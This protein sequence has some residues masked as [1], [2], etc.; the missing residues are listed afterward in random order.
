MSAEEREELEIQ[1]MKK[2]QFK[3]NPINAGIFVASGPSKKVE[4][5]ASTV[6]VEFHLSSGN[7]THSNAESIVEKS[8]PFKA[9]PV[10][11]SVFEK[12]MEKKRSIEVTV[13]KSPAFALK[14]RVK[15]K[16]VSDS[17][18]SQTKQTFHRPPPDFSNVFKPKLESNCTAPEPFSFDAK[19][20]ERLAKKEE[21]IKEILEKESAPATFKAQGMPIFDSPSTSLPPK[22][23]KPATAAE[24]FQLKCTDRVA[25]R[26]HEWEKQVEEEVRDMREK[27][28]FKANKVFLMFFVFQMH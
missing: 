9:Q 12:P 2:N 8:K 13:P 14:N 3:A 18:D 10:P 22:Q 11:M 5:K 7:A 26:V 1:E 19:D 25:M 28:T 17:I 6:P 23:I 16:V 24:P 20:N 27:A 4:K 15:A 21:K